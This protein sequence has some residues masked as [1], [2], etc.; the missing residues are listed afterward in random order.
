MEKP[1]RLTVENLACSR[2]ESPLFRGLSFA[3]ESGR[4]LIITGA[5]GVGKTTLLRALAGFLRPDE[6]SVRFDGAGD[7]VGLPQAAHFVGHRDGLRAALTVRENL[8]FAPALLGGE[9]ASA[10]EAA[11]RLDLVRLL[12]LPVGVLSAGQR[13]RTALARLLAARRPVWLL[14]EPTAALDARSQAVAGEIM[15]QHAGGGGIVIAATHQA[16]GFAARELVFAA[17]GRHSFRTSA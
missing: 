13:R 6:G 1:L 3:L 4:S 16:L 9:G 7:D 17:D 2:G 8:A 15:A 14:D 5:N 12:D 11:E 10:A